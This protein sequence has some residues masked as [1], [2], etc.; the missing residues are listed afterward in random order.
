MTVSTLISTS[1]FLS[2]HF[3]CILSTKGNTAQHF[4][5][6][7]KQHLWVFY[8]TQQR[9]IQNIG[10]IHCYLQLMGISSLGMD[11][12]TTE[13]L[14]AGFKGRAETGNIVVGV[15]CRPPSQEDQMD[16]ALYR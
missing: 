1:T 7:K 13:S 2:E 3:K 4:I 12:E 16:E 8:L 14:Q 6:C 15:S 9:T 10:L 5:A 11:E